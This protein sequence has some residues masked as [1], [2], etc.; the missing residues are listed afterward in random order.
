MMVM[1]IQACDKNRTKPCANGGYAFLSEGKITP[2]QEVYNVGDTIFFES[3]LPKLQ[4]DQINPTL[5]GDYSNSVGIL[6]DFF[7]GEFDTIAHIPIRAG[8]KFRSFAIEGSV[9]PSPVS[10]EVGKTFYY[11]ESALNYKVKFGTILSS[12]GIFAFNADGAGSLGLPRKN[13]TNASFKMTLPNN[14]PHINLYEYAIG[15]PPDTQQARGLY[16]FRVQ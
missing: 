4:Q 13:C 6:G 9:T 2:D 3:T 14:N 1:A 11:F 16:C 5:M 8:S 10:N 15:R 7:Q 12:K